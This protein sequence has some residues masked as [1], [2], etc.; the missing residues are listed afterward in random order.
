MIFKFLSIYGLLLV[1][2]GLSAENSQSA[3]HLKSHTTTKN[4]ENPLGQLAFDGA[5]TPTQII[6]ELYAD[7]VNNEEGTL[8]VE[9]TVPVVMNKKV[10]I[11]DTSGLPLRHNEPGQH[12]DEAAITVPFSID[13]DLSKTGKEDFDTFLNGMHAMLIKLQVNS[14]F[15]ESACGDMPLDSQITDTLSKALPECESIATTLA[16]KNVNGQSDWYFAKQAKSFL[17]C[18]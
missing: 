4:Q 2:L 6:A 18:Q 15:E 8:K 17:T 3:S 12:S 9:I 10:M 1:S 16:C 7:K 13:S 14:D 11:K 5:M